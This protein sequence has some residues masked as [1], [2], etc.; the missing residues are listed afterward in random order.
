MSDLKQ[1]KESVSALSVLVV[2]DEPE[3]LK[4]TTEFM[5]KF[6]D[7]VDSAENGQAALALFQQQ[8]GYDVVLSDVK[9]PIMDGWSVIKGIR[10]TGHRCFIVLMT[11]SI[12]EVES[13]HNGYDLFLLKPLNM[14]TLTDFLEKLIQVRAGYD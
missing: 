3:I 14:T 11:G 5:K 9:M 2:D 4:G 7:Q 13:A 8:G 6:F 10:E 12:E 1:L